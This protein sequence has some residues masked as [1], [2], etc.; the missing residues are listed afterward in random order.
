MTDYT[1]SSAGYGTGSGSSSITG[2]DPGSTSLADAA[3]EGYNATRGATESEDGRSIGEILGDVT[4]DVSTLMRQEVA[5]A[6]AEATQSATQAGKAVGMFAG[7]AVA[8]LLFL[9]FLSL[10][11]AVGLG[12]FIGEGADS[13]GIQWGSLIVAIIWAII[14]GVLALLGK[15]ELQRVRGVPATTETLS[16]VPNA[17]KGQEEKN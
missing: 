3:R 4:K 11:A 15:K 7:A 17:L 14:A 6:K 2:P 9:V 16:K 8:G 12:Q 5:L 10:S 1:G 13:S